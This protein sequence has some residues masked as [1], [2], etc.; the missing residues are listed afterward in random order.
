MRYYSL[1]K[2]SVHF[3]YNGFKGSPKFEISKKNL[4]TVVQCNTRMFLLN[5]LKRT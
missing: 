1:E 2:R 3:L 5:I 4:L